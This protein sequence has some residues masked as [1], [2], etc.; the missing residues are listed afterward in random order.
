MKGRNY[1]QEGYKQDLEDSTKVLNK[2]ELE[3]QLGM[4]T[5]NIPI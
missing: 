2:N 1:R 5:A 3:K 4:F